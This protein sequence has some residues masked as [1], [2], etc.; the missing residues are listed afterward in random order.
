M[1]VIYLKCF[2]V[3]TELCLFMLFY[4]LPIYLVRLS[5]KVCWTVSIDIY[6]GSQLLP[7]P[8]A[9]QAQGYLRLMGHFGTTQNY[10]L[11]L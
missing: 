2:K 11:T 7:H 1:K 5:C 6:A 9:L 3:L 10:F 8:L 4:T